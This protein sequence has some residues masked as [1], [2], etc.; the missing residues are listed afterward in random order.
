MTSGRA[1][2]VLVLFVSLSSL[3]GCA[4]FRSGGTPPPASWPISKEPGKQSISLLVTGEAVVNNERQDA[5]QGAIQRW[6]EAVEKAYKDSGLFSNVTIGA[7]E[8]DLKAEIHILDRGEVSKGMAFLSGL[9]LT[10]VPANARDEMV[11]TTALR[12][13]EGQ[14]LGT[15]N[16]KETMSTWIQFFLIFIMPFNWPNTVGTEMLYDLNRAIIDQAHRAR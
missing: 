16:E 2:H 4:S 15:Y 1:L 11:V 8:T 12:G 10:L 14:E 13:K 9:T 6:Q 7:A 5:P 3:S